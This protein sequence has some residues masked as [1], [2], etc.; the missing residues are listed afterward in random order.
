MSEEKLVP[1]IR[2]K[3]FKKEWI[4][5][6]FRNLYK[7]NIEKNKGQFGN[8]K[9]ITIASMKYNPFGNGAAVESLNNYKVLRE[10][11]VAFEGHASKKFSY[12][13]FVMNDIGDG[14]M[15]PRFT[16]LRPI[17]NMP[18]SFW[19]YYIHYEPIM[20]HRL[21]H[22]TKLGTMMN[23]LVVSDFM[24][25][26]IN[27][28]GEK[29]QSEIGKLLHSLDDLI[30]VNHGKYEKTRKLKK[31]LVQQLFPCGNVSFPGVRFVGFA[32]EWKKQKLGT[33][34]SSQIKGK[35]KA[36]MVGDESEYLDTTRLNG[37]PITKVGSATDVDK[38]DVLVLWDGSQAG[39]V[40]HGFQ[41]ALGSTLKAYKPKYD[42]G[43]LYQYLQKNQKLIFERYRTANIPHVIKDFA[44]RF[45]VDIPSVEE[46]KRVAQLL[47]DM[48]KLIENNAKKIDI[49]ESMKSAFLQKMFV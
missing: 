31:A 42:G 34:L 22:S 19:K 25:Q 40:Y 20:K 12:G 3:E 21:V 28:P 35:A 7:K 45:Y 26:H 38:N 17:S 30:I 14:I 13:R 32:D 8:D 47:N 49:L 27:I 11:D 46:Q 6:P 37:G 24:K 15:S 43:F 48:D 29:E 23:E 18:I 16:T 10:G 44:E 39:T 9:T 1:E 2:F 4:P 36:D 5:T 41:G 33:V